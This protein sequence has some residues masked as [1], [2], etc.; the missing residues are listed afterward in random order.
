MNKEERKGSWWV[1][2]K[3]RMTEKAKPINRLVRKARWTMS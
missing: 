2:P 3:A 1:K